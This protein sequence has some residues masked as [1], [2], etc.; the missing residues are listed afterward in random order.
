[1]NMETVTVFVNKKGMHMLKM[2]N[3]DIIP[4][5]GKT[6]VKQDIDQANVG[7]CDIIVV[8]PN[9]PLEPSL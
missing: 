7:L 5:I 4:N 9:V 1:M 3:G 6:V 2:P 8:F